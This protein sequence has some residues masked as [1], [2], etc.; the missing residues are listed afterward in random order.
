MAG[1]RIAEILL[2]ELDGD[3]GLSLSETKSKFT[4]LLH[5]FQDQFNF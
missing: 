2:W 4:D 5:Q 1:K 3:I